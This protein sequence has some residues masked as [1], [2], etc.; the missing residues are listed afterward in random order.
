MPNAN[1]IAGR[2]FEYRVKA[3]LINAGYYVMRAYGSKGLADLV[4]IPPLSEANYSL[5]PLMIQCKYSCKHRLQISKEEK[6]K[7]KNAVRLY[8]CTVVI[9][10]NTEEGVIMKDLYDRFITL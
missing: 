6:N 5:R 7:L 1:Y 3:K 4:A 9:A 2:N 8:N 10:Y